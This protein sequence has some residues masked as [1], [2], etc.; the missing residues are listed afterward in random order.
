M[1]INQS[2]L[3]ILLLIILAIIV[4]YLLFFYQSDNQTNQNK[5]NNTSNYTSSSTATPEV[6]LETVVSEPVAVETTRGY[7]HI[8]KSSS[9]VEEQEQSDATKE[10][11]EEENSSP[12]FSPLNPEKMTYLLSTRYIQ[13]ALPISEEE[14]NKRAEE[15]MRKYL[16]PETKAT[17]KSLHFTLDDHEEQKRAQTSAMRKAMVK[18]DDSHLINYYKKMK[19]SMNAQSF[20]ESH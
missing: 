5:R 9:N 2:T 18:D 7:I 15:Y 4:G 11:D 13:E 14:L 8:P 10:V 3:F 12:I 6:Q 17:P 19:P 16:L 20:I 1:Q